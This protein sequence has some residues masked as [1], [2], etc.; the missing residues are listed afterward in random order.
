MGGTVIRARR[1]KRRKGL[2]EGVDFQATKILKPWWKIVGSVPTDC[3]VL[4]GAEASRILAL[5]T[6]DHFKVNGSE[7]QVSGILAP[8]GSQDDQLVFARLDTAQSL[9][10][11][12][13]RVSMVEVAALCTA[14]PIEA[15]VSQIS[16]ALPDTKVRAIQEWVQGRMK[17]LNFF[18]K[19]P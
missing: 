5:E 6:G 19:F 17:T 14:C 3:G 8:T 4:L 1:G 2:S 15:M 10:H 7:L 18:R 9:L 13:G 12:E 16:R 11:K